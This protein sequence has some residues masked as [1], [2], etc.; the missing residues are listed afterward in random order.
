M[1]KTNAITNHVSKQI[2]IQLDFFCIYI[3]KCSIF[4]FDVNNSKKQSWKFSLQWL[5]ICLVKSHHLIQRN[6]SQKVQLKQS[7]CLTL[8][9]LLGT[10]VI[11]RQTATVPHSSCKQLRSFH[12][13]KSGRPLV[14]KYSRHIFMPQ[15]ICMSSVIK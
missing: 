6:K 2:K 4:T 3:L 14:E 7:S 11:C 12:V 1:R 15:W 13:V 8:L 5:K 10:G 9:N